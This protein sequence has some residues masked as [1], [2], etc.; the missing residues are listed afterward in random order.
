MGEG[1][2]D[3]GL[4]KA[5]ANNA[6]LLLSLFIAYELSYLISRKNKRL[7]QIASGLFIALICIA[8]MSMPFELHPRLV[9]HTRTILISTTAMVFGPVSTFI[10]VVAAAIYRIILGGSGLPT[11]LATII[12]SALIGLAW[13][14]WFFH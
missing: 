4:W 5:L 10:T 9:F 1:E 11:G 6:S 14:R 12:S 8:I 3:Y 2:M 13:R 7:R